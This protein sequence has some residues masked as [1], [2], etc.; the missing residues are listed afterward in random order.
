VKRSTCGN[1]R[2]AKNPRDF[3]ETPYCLTQELLNRTQLIEPI[4]EPACGKCAIVKILLSNGYRDVDYTDLDR[5][6][7]FL[8]MTGLYKTI[9]TNPPFNQA[10]EFIQKA[11]TLCDEFYFLLPLNYLHG[12][13]RYDSIYS[14]KAFPLSCIYVFD[15]YP[16]LDQPLRTDGKIKTG[17]M[18]YAWF[19]FSKKPEYREPLIRFIDIQSY[20]LSKKD[21]L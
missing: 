14:D 20:I 19:H 4:L 7:D 1:I 13:R 5:G 15:R 11:K 16:A 18:V 12:K 17:M 8:E 6:F 3:Y 2:K 10:F 21:I 9:I